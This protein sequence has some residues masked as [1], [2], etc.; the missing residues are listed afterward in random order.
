MS[1]YNFEFD[2]YTQ[3]FYLLNRL[4]KFFVKN[5]HKKNQKIL[6]KICNHLFYRP[7]STYIIVNIILMKLQKSP[8]RTLKNERFLLFLWLE[9][10]KKT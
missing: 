1:W 2:K 3:L 10:G 9:K 7:L 5:L 4:R 6:F 8:K